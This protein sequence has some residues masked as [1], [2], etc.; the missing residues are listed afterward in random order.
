MALLHELNRLKRDVRFRIKYKLS[1]P[2]PPQHPEPFLRPVVVVG[3][4][5]G[6][7]KP[8]GFNSN[9]GLIS[10]N[11]SQAATRSWGAG[12]PDATFLQ[13]NQVEGSGERAVAVRSVLAGQRTRRLHVLRWRHSIERL[14]AGLSTFDYSADEILL[15]NS[16]E[17]A[18]LAHGLL[19][20]LIPETDNANKFSNG[21]TAVLYALHSGASS[22]IISGI[23]PASSGHV[24][25]NLGLARLHTDL[26]I[27]L[28]K[29]LVSRGFPLYTADP[30][31]AQS[32]GVPLWAA[33]NEEACLCQ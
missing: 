8:D 3:S 20:R 27:R 9:Y 11:G 13:Y 2:Q 10:V 12:I 6:S 1:H 32:V 28:L 16:F 22:V 26:D 24:Y 7:N 31:V 25:N 19:G 21:V 18:C 5:P 4:A 15:V 29:E 17:R 14:R 23:N 30:D 33:K